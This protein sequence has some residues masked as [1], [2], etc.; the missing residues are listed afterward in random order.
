MLNRK[1]EGKWDK[2]NCKPAAYLRF[3]KEAGQVSQK[4]IG[5]PGMYSALQ[6]FYKD[7]WLPNACR[8]VKWLGHSSASW[9][10]DGTHVGKQGVGRLKRCIFELKRV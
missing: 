10:S 1:D 8:R 5:S 3:T 9:S 4:H 6:V 2:E 7:L